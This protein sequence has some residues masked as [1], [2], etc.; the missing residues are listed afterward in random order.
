MFFGRPCKQVLQMP[1]NISLLIFSVLGRIFFK[2]VGGNFGL[3]REL[4]NDPFDNFLASRV[5]SLQIY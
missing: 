4:K 1:Q 3:E 5:W 2:G